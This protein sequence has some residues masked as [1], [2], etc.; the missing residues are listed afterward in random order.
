MAW[1]K[2]LVNLIRNDRLSS[3]IDR[4]LQFHIDE[5]VAELVASG[6]SAADARREAERRFGGLLRQRER[7]RDMN[8]LVWLDTVLADVRFATRGL[9]RSPAFSLVAILSLALGIG[10][11]TAIFSLIDAVLLQSLPVHR[12]EELV[13]ITRGSTESAVVTNP[14]WEELRDRE[15]FFAGI[16]AYG[17]ARFNLAEAGE[18]R[19]VPG[20]W[21]SG[22]Y[23]ATLGVRPAL[24]RLLSREDDVRGCPAIAVVSHAFWRSEFGSDPGAIGRTLSLDGHAHTVVGVTDPRFTGVNT[25]I[26]G[27]VYAPLCSREIH[28]EGVLD[29]RSHWNLQ[30]MG[31]LASGQTLAPVQARLAAIS[32]A[33]HAASVP[34][35]WGVERRRGFLEARLGAELSPNGNSFLRRQYSQPLFALMA[36]VGVVLLIACVNIASLLLARGAARQREVAVRLAIGAGRARL[37]RQW[38]TES[39]L[40]AMLGAAVGIVFAQ[41]SSRLLVAMLSSSFLPVYLDLSINAR[42]L[43]FT[44]LVATITGILFGLAPALSSARMEPQI[45]MRGTGGHGTT[46]GH[47]RFRAAS[48]LV[49]AQVALSLVLIV[50]AGLL[51]GTFRRLTTLDAGF[52]RDGVLLVQVNIPQAVQAENRGIVYRTLLERFRDLPGTHSASASDITPVGGSTWNNFVAVEGHTAASREDELVYF[53]AVSEGYF[54]TMGTALLAGRDFDRS[55]V[56]GSER[57]ALINLA[58]ARKFFA[59]DS[60]IGRD[61]RIRTTG[62][63]FEPSVRVIGVVEDAKYETLRE[64]SLPTAYLSMNQDPT[65]WSTIYQLRSTGT[66]ESLISGVKEV[67]EQVNPGLSLQL[68][69]LDAQVAESLTRERMLA[70]L[71]TFFGGLALLLSV[72]G[73]YGTL[74][75]RVARRRKEIGVRLALG[76]APA[77]M[78]RMVL[79]EA[80]TVILAG[81]VV[82]VAATLASARLI[83]SFLFDLA[84]TDARTLIL[85]VALLALVA[86]A[87]A[88]VPAWRAANTGALTPL[89]E[90]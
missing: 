28:S 58:M 12:P 69:T 30:V 19:T 67:I 10:A 85:S 61:F 16:F 38:L 17:D 75:Y 80:G 34:T 56:P 90:E 25:G 68:R 24:G 74:S 22:E 84:P 35:E 60:P 8:V 45:A 88:A 50:T 27:Q 37:W 39:L 77:Q 7:T 5:R 54:A 55:D 29:Q 71:S 41:W 49:G 76:A 46:E 59:D 51:V 83:S 52:E 32:P 53:N 23:F 78:L 89:R 44:I 82:G 66:P 79:R 73:L 43:G 2:R 18:E 21:V 6:M 72:M 33:V 81:L 26:A 11:N 64:E 42:V 57:V 9:L 48:A 47:P 62:D 20:N 13:R 70:V 3:D 4:E 36:V 15:D 40:L 31:R 1:F 86:F 63:G 65:P 14:L 87:A